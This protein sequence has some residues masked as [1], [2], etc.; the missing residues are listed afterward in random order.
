MPATLGT[1]RL[2][3]V[4]QD[5]PEREAEITEYA[6]EKRANMADHVRMKPQTISISGVIVG[7]DAASRMVQLEK[8]QSSGE[9]IPY[10]HRIKRQK[11]LIQQ[12]NSTHGT[13]VGNGL[14][15]DIT[16]REVTLA[17]SSS[18]DLLS[19]DVSSQ[20]KD[21]DNLGRQQVQEGS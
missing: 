5:E 17:E 2:D 4:E 19:V 21:I 1:V 9:M 14:Q 10:R 20:V 6:V 3:T 16:L 15:F 11:V 18:V 12:F 7:P 13:K 8:Y